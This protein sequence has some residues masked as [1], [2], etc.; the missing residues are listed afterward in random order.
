MAYMSQ[1][2][3]NKLAP[4]IKAI[5][6]K[7]KVTGSLS[8][9]NHS[10]LVL[11]IKGGKLDFIGNFNQVAEK[12]GAAFGR[13]IESD[14]FEVNP[15]WVSESYSG[16]VRDFLVEMVAAMKGPDFFDH[17]D[18]QTDYFHVSHYINIKVGRWNKPYILVD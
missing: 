2:Q 6:A 13:R 11:T 3:K 17:S 15:H 16:D 7:Y 18:M 12:K 10:T 4:A 5:L 1:E 14:Y 9:N 8:V